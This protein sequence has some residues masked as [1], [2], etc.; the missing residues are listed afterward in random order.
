MPPDTCR[1][2]HDWTAHYHWRPG[3][4]CG[5]C[6]HARCGSFRRRRPDVLWLAVV[7]L[8]MAALTVPLI[9]FWPVT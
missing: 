5:T 3:D 1:C 9:L 6:G 7:V 8:L 2:G 4:D